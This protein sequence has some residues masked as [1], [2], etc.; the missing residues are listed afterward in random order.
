MIELGDYQDPTVGAFFAPKKDR[1]LRLIP[2]TRCVNS[3]FVEPRRT[4]LPSPAARAAVRTRS[5]APL[6]L[7]QTDV[8]NAFF[9][10]RT[11]PGLSKYFRLPPVDEEMLRAVNPTAPQGLTGKRASPRLCALAMG[12]AWSLYFCQEM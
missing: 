12:W 9:R 5:D 10:V 2:D 1:K 4:H 7:A 6:Y 11:P 3:L 8:N